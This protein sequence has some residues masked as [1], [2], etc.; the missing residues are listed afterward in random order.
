M[1]KAQEPRRSSSVNRDQVSP[2]A[3]EPHMSAATAE[4]LSSLY[5]AVGSP[6]QRVEVISREQAARIRQN[7][8]H[9][10]SD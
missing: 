1:G 5:E 2:T 10:E 7:Q 8:N 4:S 3:S 9:E 6:A